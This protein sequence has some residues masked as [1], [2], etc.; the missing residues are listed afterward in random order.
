MHRSLR[1]GLAVTAC[2]T[3]LGLVG[4]AG[5]ASAHVSITEG[6]VTA[7]AYE[8]LT[9]GFAHGCGESPTTEIRI[10]IPESIPTPAPTINANWDVEKVMET[11]ETPVEAGHG[12]TIDERVAEV[13]Y[14][15]KTPLPDGFRDTFQLSVKIPDDAAGETLYF[16]TVQTCE[17]GETRWIELPADGQSSDDLESPAPSVEVL[18]AGAGDAHGADGAT[19]AAADDV[20]DGADDGADDAANDGEDDGAVA[21]SASAVTPD[22]TS[23]DDGTD[24][25]TWVALAVGV[26]GVGIGGAALA[27][28]RKR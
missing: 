22:S 19:D 8:V 24:P 7:G 23:S 26:V 17:A 18:A 13:V 3:A 21:E 25:L 11:L 5:P 6:E 15:A 14:T 16:P 9:F 1:R 2:A 27:T 28:S 10:Q 12:T 4:V 20:A